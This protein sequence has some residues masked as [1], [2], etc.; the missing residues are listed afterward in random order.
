MALLMMNCIKHTSIEDPNNGEIVCSSCGVVLKEKLPVEDEP[1]TVF[2]DAA[3]LERSHRSP[4]VGTSTMMA[5]K[6]HTHQ[7]PDP[8]FKSLNIL[9]SRIRVSDGGSRKQVHDLTYSICNKL[10]LP[11]YVKLDIEKLH[12]RIRSVNMQR[13]HAIDTMVAACTLVICRRNDIPKTIR[14]ITKIANVNQKNVFKLYRFITEK[15]D[16]DIKFATPESYISSVSTKLGTSEI[17]SLRARNIIKELRKQRHQ[18]QGGKNPVVITCGALYLS[19][20]LNNE[21][22][23]QKQFALASG[24]TEVSLRR[25]VHDIK[26]TLGEDRLYELLNAKST[27]IL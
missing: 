27:G 16:I 5:R 15:F 7:N 1:F 11:E 8:K 22:R 17:V 13:G 25:A 20:I 14:E 19:A 2:H 4:N 21:A 12:D 23:T 26:A 9:D 3:Q 10:G 18:I 24:I 6:T